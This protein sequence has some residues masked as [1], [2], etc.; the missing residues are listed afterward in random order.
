MY[1]EHIKDKDYKHVCEVFKT[2]KFKTLHDY[3]DFYLMIDVLLLCDVFEDFRENCYKN[4]G[5]EILNY[6]TLPSYSFDAMLKMTKVNIELIK[7]I[8]IYTMFENS[9]KGG[10][11]NVRNK[12]YVKANNKY[13]KDYNPKE[14]SSYILH[15][16]ANNLYGHAQ[17]RPLPTG[18]FTRLF[19]KQCLSISQILEYNDE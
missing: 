11:S 10:Y 14:K 15:I 5:L 16:D 3:H 6:L 1:D 7:D 13:L 8:D 2:L 9:I 18:N 12:R 19:R 4:Y 17:V